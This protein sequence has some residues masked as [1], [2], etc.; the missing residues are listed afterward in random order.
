M[1]FLMQSK[2][3]SSLIHMNK[4]VDLTFSW[5]ELETEKRLE[6]DSQ[7]ESEVTKPCLLCFKVPFKCFL[8]EKGR[9]QPVPMKCGKR[10]IK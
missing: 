5:K 1:L 8:T 4:H 9:I 6:H 7:L 2:I 10:G 3:K